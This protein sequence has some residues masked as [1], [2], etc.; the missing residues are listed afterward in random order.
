[1]GKNIYIVIAILFTSVSCKTIDIANKNSVE[2]MP[3][4]FVHS[5]DTSS[6]EIAKWRAFFFDDNLKKLIDTA[7]LNN[8]DLKATLQKLE[9]YKSGIT[10]H[11]GIRLP[12]VNLNIASGVRKFGDYTMD[13][14][15]NYDT[16]FSTNINDKQQIPNPLP[17]YYLG[18]QSFWEID[19][20]GKLKSKKKAALA[21]FIA[22]QHGKDLIV[23]TLISEVATA[24]FE[25]LALDNEVKILDDNIALQ[26][27]ALD[28]VIA[29]KQVAKANE[30]AVELLHAQLLNSKS[31]KKKVEQKLIECESRLNFLTGSYV[32]K[33]ERDTLY[34]AQRIDTLL[35]VGIPTDLLKNRPDIK[36]AE[37]EIVAKNADLH[38]ARAAFY[39]SLTINSALGLQSFKAFLLLETPASL[40]Y[41]LFGGLVTP[42]VNRRKI[43]A[44]LM[45]SKAEQKIA[46]I[47]YEKTLVNAFNEVYVSVKNINNTRQM[48]AYKNEEVE[49]LK[50]SISTS[51]ELFKAG[52]AGY[53]EIITSQKNALQSQLE[54]TEYYKMQN[55]AL[56]NLYKSIG[57]GWN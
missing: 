56:V 1:M 41:N 28:L 2:K 55:I 47:N 36:Q 44:D 21:S 48:Y 33:N 14:V 8:Y 17:D 52:R 24:Y 25:L 30:L 43:K 49:I 51:T 7:L 31:T 3:E 38:A 53:L 34:F 27:A 11:K 19:L 6:A 46:Y 26:Q 10:L 54:L 16:Q 45:A 5:Q 29:Q 35:K 57:G 50:K 22:S 18:F 15:G 20:W 23:T 37:F 12:E 4:F 9:I 40:A 13:G 39:P 32:K 42:V